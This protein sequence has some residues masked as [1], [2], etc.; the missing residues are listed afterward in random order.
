MT[1]AGVKAACR[2]SENAARFDILEP[3]KAVHIWIYFSCL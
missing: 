3:V 1:L 2:P